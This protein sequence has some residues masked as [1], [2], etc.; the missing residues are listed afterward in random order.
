[1]K[2]ADLRKVLR[3]SANALSRKAISEQELDCA[4]DNIQAALK[5]YK[6]E[7]RREYWHKAWHK[8]QSEPLF[9]LFW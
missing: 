9:R 1:M 2:R 3:Q 4:L 7:R 6:W 8:S 5:Q